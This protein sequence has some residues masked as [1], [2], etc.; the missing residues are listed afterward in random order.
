ME[1]EYM[2]MDDRTRADSALQPLSKL[3]G[4]SV[5]PDDPDVRG[6]NVVGSDGE[7]IG[8]VDDLLV[9]TNRMKVA[10]LEV[11]IKGGGDHVHV[12]VE[13]VDV[14]RSNKQIRIAG[15]APGS[16]AA[17]GT[18]YTDRSHTDRSD[19]DRSGG[20]AN[21]EAYGS[22]RRTEGDR[23]VVTRSEEELQVG[24]RGV[25]EGEVV[26]GKHVETERVQ[27]PVNLRRE[28]A[29]I[30]RRPVE[31]GHS[32]EIEMHGDEIRVPL[33]REEAVV[34]KRPVVKEELVVGKKTVEEQQNVE[35]E[36][37]REEFDVDER[38]TTGR[39][40]RT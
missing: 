13:Q 40:R 11:D 32:G 12:P 39:K 26:V 2:A 24:K 9:D 21:Y 1:E 14:D 7:K 27:K 33:S 6:W 8:K 25:Q 4:Y 35:A 31:G 22:A 29:Y 18:A 19:T 38:N 20:Q 16:T 3:S 28:E 30:E 23:N 36:V 15:Y 34:E 5:G 17:S 10:A 37:R